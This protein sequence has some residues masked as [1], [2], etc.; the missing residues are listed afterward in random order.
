MASEAAR[1]HGVVDER[2]FEGVTRSILHA[3]LDCIVVI[4][5][6][7][8]VVEWNPAAEQTFGYTR[9]E[10]VGS[11]LADLIV[12]PDMREAHRRGLA[13][14]LAT[15]TGRMLGRRLELEAVRSDG[16]SL[17]VE[18]TITRLDRH[19][20]LF[21]GYL[22]DITRHRHSVEAA[23]EAE[24]RYRTLVE[25]L[26]VVTYS[27][28]LGPTGRWIYVSPQIEVMTG[29]SPE[30]WMA[31]P[32]LW[33]RRLHPADRDHVTSGSTSSTGCWP[34]TGTWS[35]CATRRRASPGAAEGHVWWRV[36]SWTSPSSVAPRRA[37]AIT[38]TTTSSPGSSTGGASR[39]SSSAA[40]AARGAAGR[41]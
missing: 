19:P 13:R 5:A 7:G 29:Y 25:R 3:A 1:L 15:G 35:V 30:E 40:G 12:P 11:D 9:E 4:A 36:C 6:H 2:L 10:A 16:S 38:P 22:R 17:P 24:R 8:R 23:E 31:D 26:P 21:V 28:E 34:G 27:A 41:W 39:R 37:C 18:L 20:P 14:N 32:E 33:Y